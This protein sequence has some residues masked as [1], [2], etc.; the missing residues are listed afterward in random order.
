MTGGEPLG[1]GDG[2]A[3][4]DVAARLDERALEAWGRAI[5]AVAVPGRVFVALYGP[6]GAGK[7]TLVRAACAGAGLGEPVTSPTFTLVQRYADGAPVYHVDLYRIERASELVELGWDDLE[8]GDNAVFVE[9]ADRAWN[10]LP[11]DRWE[12]RLSFSPGGGARNVEARRKGTA[13]P[14]PAPTGTAGIGEGVVGA[15]EGLA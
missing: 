8:S 9:W 3:P 14:I 2:G 10:R 11:P 1:P 15:G 5:G 4:P 6:L 13:P 7:T 12:I